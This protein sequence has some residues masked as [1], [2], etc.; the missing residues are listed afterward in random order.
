[1]MATPIL[2]FLVLIIGCSS[3]AYNVSL[4]T[5][6]VI[7]DLHYY[8]NSAS[9]NLNI[10]QQVNDTQ[11]IYNLCKQV[12]VYCLYQNAVITASM[13]VISKVNKTCTPYVQTI[14][15]LINQT[16]ITSGIRVA[17]VSPKNE[18]IIIDTPCNGEGI[19][20]PAVH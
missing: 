19:A 17:Y 20:C 9:N 1:M 11:M 2:L 18:T 3:Q 10:V 4:C 15:G 8:I 7:G 16:V 5:D 12:Q 6:I 14:V 13:V